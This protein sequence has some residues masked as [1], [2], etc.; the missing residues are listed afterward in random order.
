[1]RFVYKTVIF[2]QIIQLDSCIFML[3]MI[4]LNEVKEKYQKPEHKYCW[5]YF[6]FFRLLYF[7]E[8]RKLYFSSL[9]KFDDIFEGASKDFV[10][11]MNALF[12]L[13]KRDFTNQKSA[14]TDEN[15]DS[16]IKR[17]KY[18]NTIQMDFFANCF[19][20]SNSESEAMWNMHGGNFGVAVQFDFNQ[21]F[22][23]I[24]NYYENVI[25]DSFNLIYGY[26]D[27]ELFLDYHVLFN[28]NNAKCIF[29]PFL[30]NETHK[31]EQEYR[32]ILKKSSPINKDFVEIDIPKETSFKVFF[33]SNTENWQIL[34][35]RQLLKKYD[36]DNIYIS[37][38]LSRKTLQNQ[39]KIII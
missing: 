22:E 17:I 9:D 14:Y 24:C 32:F 38:I 12:K 15:K 18:L 23:I 33:P 21:I 6:D 7:L 16:L 39:L 3:K 20:S 5:K 25:K 28:I 8:K 35:I 37:S 34:L 4:E 10:F 27:Y 36:I 13:I 19:Y 1:M 29:N 30:K 11:E 2:S 26:L 31:Y